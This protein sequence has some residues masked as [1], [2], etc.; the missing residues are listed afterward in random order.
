MLVRP[1]A[2]LYSAGQVLS[3]VIK[4]LPG[5][6]GCHTSFEIFQKSFRWYCEIERHISKIVKLHDFT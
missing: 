4:C 1:K 2:L 5:V 3:V 6:K